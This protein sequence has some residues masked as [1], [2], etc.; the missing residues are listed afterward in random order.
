MDHILTWQIAGI[1]PGTGAS[2][3]S[4]MLFDPLLRLLIDDSS[5]KPSNP[6]GDTCSVLELRIG[7]IGN[8][9][10]RLLTNGSQYDLHCD[11]IIDFN[12]KVI[13]INLQILFFE[14]LLLFHFLRFYLILN[15]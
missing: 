15:N 1:C 8:S 12:S 9:I 14:G 2:R 13:S 7:R 11:L 4:S 5:A 6:A 3:N 10:R